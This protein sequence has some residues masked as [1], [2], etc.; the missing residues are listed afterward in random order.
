MKYQIVAV[1][2]TGRS[3]LNLDKRKQ[4][5]HAKREKR[6]FDGEK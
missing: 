2:V 3:G 6:K 1:E 4:V 5:R